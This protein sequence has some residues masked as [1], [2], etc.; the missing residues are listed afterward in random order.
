MQKVDEYLH[1]FGL[2]EYGELPFMK[3]ISE[4]TKIPTSALVL[5]FVVVLILLM[6]T[7]YVSE[8]LTTFVIFFIPAFKTFKALHT[9]DKK[10]DEQMLTYWVVFASVYTFDQLFST[11]LGF[12]GFY[13]VIRCLLLALLFGSEKYGAK[14]IYTRAVK[15]FFEK[16]GSKFDQIMAPI[17]EQGHR[18]SRYLETQKDDIMRI[19]KNQ[20]DLKASTNSDKQ[21][22]D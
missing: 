7:P 12:F 2:L 20:A 9:E 5:V 14:F 13:T 6:F 8:I 3:K 22:Q 16:F 10:D 17:E 11:I 21:K 4:K 1:K 15:P 18:I 19:S